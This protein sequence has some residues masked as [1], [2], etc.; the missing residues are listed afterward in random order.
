MK[1]TIKSLNV[2]IVQAKIITSKF[3]NELVLTHSK[4]TDKIF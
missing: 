4:L 2:E 1:D 3:R